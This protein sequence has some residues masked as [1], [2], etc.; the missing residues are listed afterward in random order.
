[1]EGLGATALLPKR[2]SAPLVLDDEGCRAFVQETIV[3]DC[4][5]KHANALSFQANGQRR[6]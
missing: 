6:A 4:S 2:L 1:M 3:F 5:I